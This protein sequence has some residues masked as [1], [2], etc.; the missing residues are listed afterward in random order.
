MF[1]LLRKLSF[2]N[3][4]SGHCHYVFEI[5]KDS[6]RNYLDRNSS[7]F[8]RYKSFCTCV[9]TRYINRFESKN[10]V[11]FDDT[12]AD[13]VII[14]EEEESEGDANT[15]KLHGIC[16]GGGYTVGALSVTRGG[17]S[18]RSDDTVRLRAN[19]FPV[20]LNFHP[21]TERCNVY[22]TEKGIG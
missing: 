1:S 11:S 8:L 3:D 20:K 10:R 18:Y 9:S 12:G 16:E 15:D 19:I 4:R 22:A 21:D 6:V 17:L 2:S 14:I 13:R 7:E 5:F